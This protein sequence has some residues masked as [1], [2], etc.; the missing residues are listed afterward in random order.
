MPT[1]NE[2]MDLMKARERQARKDRE[3][4]NRAKVEV[5]RRAQ[6]AVEHP[7]WQLLMREIDDL[8][9][10]AQ[11]EMVAKAAKITAV[12]GEALLALQRDL[13]WAEAAAATLLHVKEIIPQ[14]IEAGERAAQELKSL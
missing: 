8:Q 3:P 7:G 2:V 12:G 10:K 14:H 13:I 11:D 5:A 6:T 9:Q 4:A 1:F